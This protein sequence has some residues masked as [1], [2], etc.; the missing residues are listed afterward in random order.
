MD[1]P[2]DDIRL[3]AALDG[4]GAGL[5]CAT[6]KPTGARLMHARYSFDQETRRATRSRIIDDLMLSVAIA[7]LFKPAPTK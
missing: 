7:G 1:I 4:I 2:Y 5:Y 3:E 6:Y